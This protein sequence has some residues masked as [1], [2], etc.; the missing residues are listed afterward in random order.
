M[1][2][3]KAFLGQNLTMDAIIFNKY[4]MTIIDFRGKMGIFANEEVNRI[5]NTLYSG[6]EK[7]AI[8]INVVILLYLGIQIVLNVGG[9]KQSK[10]FKNLE[11]HIK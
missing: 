7:V 5:I 10:Y 11:K 4:D 8:V 3:T 6:F 1:L 9:E 2:I